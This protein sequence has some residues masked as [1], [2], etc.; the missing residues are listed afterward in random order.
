MREILHIQGGQCGNQ[1]GSKFWEVVCDEHGIDPTGRYHVVDS[2][3][4]CSD[5]DFVFS[6]LCLFRT[7][8][9]L[10]KFKKIKT[11]SIFEN[12]KEIYDGN[13]V[14]KLTFQ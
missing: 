4:L 1:I 6:F 5:N 3:K 2:K 11:N 8:E 13:S 12:I 10:V 9:F 14:Y 7:F